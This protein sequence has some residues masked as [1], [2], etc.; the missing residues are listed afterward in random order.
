MCKNKKMSYYS[1]IDSQKRKGLLKS[2]F[3]TR[4]SYSV[5]DE[6][7]SGLSKAD[8]NAIRKGQNSLS[9]CLID[10]ETNVDLEN[11]DSI[12]STGNHEASIPFIDSDEDI[13]N[14]DNVIVSPPVQMSTHDIEEIAGA[15][16]KLCYF[17]YE[18]SY[19]VLPNQEHTDPAY[20]PDTNEHGH[21]AKGRHWDA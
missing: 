5:Q 9:T 7:N 18:S 2:V 4:A 6:N 8:C 1:K 11:D 20:V 16:K 21:D 14:K 17:Q 12:S 10:P 3:R 19:Q 13:D 15:R